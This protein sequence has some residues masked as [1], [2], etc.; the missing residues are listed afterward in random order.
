MARAQAMQPGDKLSAG[1]E[2]FEFACNLSRA[3]IQA[4]HPDADA[5]EIERIL[6]AR[7]ELGQ[8]LELEGWKP[9]LDGTDEE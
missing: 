1:I 9:N 8:K 7:I 5:A 4:D 2:L 3:G 6:A